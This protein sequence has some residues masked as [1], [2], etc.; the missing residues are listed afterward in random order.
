VYCTKLNF[1]FKSVYL[2]ALQTR[3][4]NGANNVIKNIDGTKNG[5]KHCQQNGKDSLSWAS[6]QKKLT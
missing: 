5:N 1:T 3:I 6:G 2:Y 4:L